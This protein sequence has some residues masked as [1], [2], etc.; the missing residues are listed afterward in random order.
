MLSA[1]K[2]KSTVNADSGLA[3]A[4]APEYPSRLIPPVQ[5]FV[6]VESLVPYI[7][8]LYFYWA[9]RVKEDSDEGRLLRKDAEM[10]LADMAKNPD[11][12]VNV[13]QAFYKARNVEGTGI[14]FVLNEGTCPCCNLTVIIPTPRQSA[15]RGD[16]T[17]RTA[18][19]SLCDFVPAAD[20]QVGTFAC[21]VSTEFVKRLERLKAEHTDDYAMLL[22]HTLGDRLVE[23]AAERMSHL[24]EEQY[25]W[26]GIRPAIGYPSLPDQRAIFQLS[27]LID[28]GSIGITLTEN[29]AMYPQSSVCGLL[30]SHPQ[31]RYFSID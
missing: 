25:Q 11:F 23:A 29:G 16:G 31:A 19:L 3:D 24:L 13:L 21:T 7:D 28:F 12:G 2:Y 5:E 17:R 6:T 8:W 30:I 27:R 1:D 14:E 10:M 22:M 15:Y 9:W 4:I 20:G 26:R 18:P